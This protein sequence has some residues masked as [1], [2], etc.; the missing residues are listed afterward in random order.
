MA[1]IA[2]WPLGT[3][4]SKS[5]DDSGSATPV[6]GKIT[7]SASGILNQN[8][9]ILS[10]AAY[11]FDWYPGA[12]G[13]AI[14][15]YQKKIDSDDF[16][17]TAVLDSLDAAGITTNVEK[18]LDPGDYSVVFYVSAPATPPNHYA[19]VRVTVNGNM[20]VNAP[21]WASWIVP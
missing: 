15:G 18:I 7:V 13:A 1:V 14:A 6:K 16:S 4:C 5:K 20:S 12:T 2:L 21:A 9:N 11:P 10:V 19:E 17:M 3:G 8:K